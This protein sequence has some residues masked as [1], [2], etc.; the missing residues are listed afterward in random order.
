VLFSTLFAVLFAAAGPASA[1]AS[2]V[3]SDPVDG[4]RLKAAPATVIITFDQPVGLGDVGY[5]HV[6][7]QNGNKVDAGPAFHPNGN[8]A[9]VEDKLKPG[10]GDGTYT[11]SFRIIS[12]DSHPVA[13]TVRFIVGN[14]VLSAA[15]PAGATVNHATTVVFDMARWV[16]F[17]GFALIAG[18]WLWLSVWPAGRSDRRARVVAWTG[19]GAGAVGA[20]AETVLQGPYTA[21][22]GLSNITRWQLLDSTLHASF[23]EYHCVRLVLIG[24]V[25]LFFGVA[26]Q[27]AAQPEAQPEAEPVPAATPPMPER[28]RRRFVLGALFGLLILAMAYTFAEVGHPETTSPT[29]VSVPDD[30]AHITA[31]A[32]WLGGLVLLAACVFPR[33]D[34]DELRVVV[35]MFSRVAI[36]AIAV[37]AASGTYLALRGVQTVDAIFTTTYGLLVVVKVALLLGIVV[38]GYGNRSV[39]RR[40]DPVGSAERVRRS[41]L[42]EV[43]LAIG[44]LVATSLLVAQPRGAEALAVVRAH[45]RSGAVDIGGGRIVT[46]TLDPGKHGDIAATVVLTGAQPV[47]VTATAVLPSRQLGPIPL[48]L[49]PNGHDVYGASGVLLPAAGNW[50]IDLV[51]T[52]SKFSATT[53]SVT[54]HL[55]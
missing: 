17:A 52:T 48:D 46:V 31:M 40:R 37:L 5:L 45:P 29:W 33:R 2:V 38:L 14:G 28:P 3:S 9:Q 15:P 12:A 51:V 7:D 13:G 34:P 23:G 44:I 25:A 54:I 27:P 43:V 55:Y 4:S 21:G 49:R 30:M 47:Q 19:V 20:V 39:L 35:P 22:T 16:S 42:V 32:V 36:I 24:V 11:A 8:G 41:V 53:G 26:M 10:L 6:T 18:S 50:R 1:H